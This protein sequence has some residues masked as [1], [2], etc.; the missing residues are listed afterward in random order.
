MTEI[1]DLKLD[2]KRYKVVFPDGGP[3]RA[4]A[5]TRHS[6]PH[7][8]RVSGPKLYDHVVKAYRP[9]TKRRL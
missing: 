8:K 3:P 6:N 4:Y 7:F 9:K 1:V 2:G 5:L